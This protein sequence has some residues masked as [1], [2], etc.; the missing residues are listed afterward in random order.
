[1]KKIIKFKDKTYVIELKKV[2]V[3]DG[4]LIERPYCKELKDYKNYPVHSHVKA[5]QP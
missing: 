4:S 1:M 5:L 2:K 3:R